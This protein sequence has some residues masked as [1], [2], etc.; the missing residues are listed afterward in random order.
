MYQSTIMS[1][2]LISSGNFYVE[3]VSAAHRIPKTPNKYLRYANEHT[4]DRLVC[5]VSGK[6][7]FDIFNDN[8]IIAKSGDVVYIPYNIAYSSEWDENEKPEVYSINYIM[9]DLNG[10][11]ITFSSE[12]MKFNNSDKFITLGIFK[13]CYHAFSSEKYAFALKC[14]YIFLKLIYTFITAENSQNHSKVSKAIEFIKANYLEEF[15]INDLA[16]MC[17]LGECMF[18]RCFK[19]ELGTSPI[20]YRNELRI[21]KA[22]ELLVSENYSVTEVMEFTG[23][24]DAS[25]FN[26]CF[27][28]RIGKTPSECKQ[29]H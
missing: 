11:R 23:F 4:H 17:N 3:A 20:K 29:G 15:S 25:Y 5:I 6:C 27:K 8:P 2:E 9:K 21:Q 26:K 1:K 14:N 18:R 22:Y 7:K 24:Y 28:S 13:E 19:A 16:K 10:Y 12:I